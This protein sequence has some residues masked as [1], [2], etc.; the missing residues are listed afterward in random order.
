MISPGVMEVE[1][2]KRIILDY[3]KLSALT[4]SLKEID[5]K[6]VVT[7]GTYDLIHIGHCRYLCKAKAL[8][9]VLIVGI[10]TDRAVKT[11]KEPYRP[12]VPQ[13]ERLEML[14][15]QRP[16]DFITL[17]DDV[18]EQGRWQYDLLRAIRPDFFQAVEGSYPRE[19]LDEIKTFCGE[20][21]VLPRQAETSTSQQIR[22]AFKHNL[23]KVMDT[24]DTS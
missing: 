2:N 7:I 24:F 19:Q 9:D 21:V 8:G 13:G 23:Q 16:V 22:R 1:C 20:V 6:I 5:W 12:I 14:A 15:Y 18:N 3:T 10:D 11:Y 4:N 17:I